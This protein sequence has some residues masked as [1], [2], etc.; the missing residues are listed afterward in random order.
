MR[1]EYKHSPNILVRLLNTV[2][3]P[4]ALEEQGLNNGS[5]LRKE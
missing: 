1:F 3:T 5:K 2:T 4:K